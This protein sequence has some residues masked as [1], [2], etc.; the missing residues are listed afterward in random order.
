M[1][2]GP[3]RRSG[4]PWQRILV[5]LARHGYP[6]HQIAACLQDLSGDALSLLARQDHL[7]PDRIEAL[8]EEDAGLRWTT[9][10][11][12]GHRRRLGIASRVP[13]LAPL[14]LWLYRSQRD[15]QLAR[16]LLSFG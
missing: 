16:L 12:R 5:C 3:Y 1:Q 7:D 4:E 8:R 10:M 2:R 6:D 11:A 15:K 9:H 14:W 13:R